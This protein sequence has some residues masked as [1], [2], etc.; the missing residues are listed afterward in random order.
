MSSCKYSNES[1]RP[2]GTRITL[3]SVI[4]FAA[5]SVAAEA[6]P[7][8]Y[9]NSGA[10]IDTATNEVVGTTVS[11]TGIA[12]SPDGRYVA[13]AS[14]GGL[15]RG[16]GIVSIADTLTGK[17]S[18]ARAGDFPTAV[19]FGADGKRVYVTNDYQHGICTM[20]CT[21][22]V[23]VVDAA[24]GKSSAIDFG[25]YTEAAAASPSGAIALVS[26]YDSVVTILNANPSGAVNVGDFPSAAA[27]SPD[28][29]RAYI[30]NQG[31]TN[32]SVIDMA[33]LSVVDTIAVAG[34][35][36][37]IAITPDGSRAYVT[38]LNGI[39]SVVD[40]AAKAVVASVPVADLQGGVAVTPDG[41]HVYAGGY[42]NISVIDTAT[43]SIVAAIPGGGSQIAIVPPPP[44]VPFLSFSAR[45]AIRF[46]TIPHRDDFDFHCHFTLRG[47]EGNGF[48][49]DIDP[50]T[51]QV[52]TFTVTIPPRSFTKLGRGSFV[53]AG[54]IGG[55]R[56]HA[57]IRPAG[58]LRY[59]VEVRGEGAD[60]AGSKNPIQVSLV[61]GNDS[62]TASVDAHT[63]AF[64][65]Q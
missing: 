11:G 52:G 23:W 45:A 27:F 43:N 63:L 29:T 1:G 61:F 44:G 34:G 12:V 2:A 64:W 20:G 31:G 14:G 18:T 15:A 13:A 42:Q 40:T 56:L 28:G 32:L 57:R 10:V 17:V 62:G 49:P 6:A 50:V 47:T 59:A 37:G 41:K 24:T 35:P 39:V 21:Q 25:M 53:F 9:V 38:T 26:F 46:G 51:V 48:N 22:E 8:V 4:G 7:F 60:L 36:N 16:Q 30:A 3:A 54:I 19:A 58:S 55:V 33:T 65:R 5:L